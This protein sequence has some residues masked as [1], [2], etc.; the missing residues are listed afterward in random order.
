MANSRQHMAIADVFTKI[1]IDIGKFYRRGFS[2]D[3]CKFKLTKALLSFYFL[4][5]P[6]FMY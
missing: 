6:L 5:Q 4:N 2:L 3:A 1:L